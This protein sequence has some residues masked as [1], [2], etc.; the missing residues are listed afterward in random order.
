MEEMKQLIQIFIVEDHPIFTEGLVA[1]IENEND[2]TVCG[3]ARSVEQAIPLI[4]KKLPDMTITDITFKNGL[5][6][7]EL[8]KAIKKQF[9]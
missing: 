2:M 1:K 6:G 5:S 9:Q 4:E 3:T 8:I 7:F